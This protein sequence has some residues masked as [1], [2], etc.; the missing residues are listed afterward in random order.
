[1]AEIS[2]YYRKSGL[3]NTMVTSDFT[4]KVEIW[5]FVYV[6]WKICNI[7]VIIG[8]V[9]SLWTW[10]WGRYHVPQN[11]F[12]VLLFSSFISKVA[13]V[14]L[15]SLYFLRSMHM[16]LQPVNMMQQLYAATSSLYHCI[17]NTRS[18]T[19]IVKLYKWVTG[20][21]H[22][23][24]QQVMLETSLSKRSI[25]M[26]PTRNTPYALPQ[27]INRKS[28]LISCYARIRCRVKTNSTTASYVLTPNTKL[29]VLLFLNA[30]L[31]VLE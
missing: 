5:L 22:H 21:Q 27:Q 28:R 20:V 10:L 24:T 12:L 23:D 9:Q 15:T 7:T 19:V 4:P 13:Q 31:H 26:A 1:M 16:K 25:T 14:I 29:A 17:P 6:Q 3:R 11:V 8:T 18:W 30:V 2:A